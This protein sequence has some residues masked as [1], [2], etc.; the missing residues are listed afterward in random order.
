MTTRIRKMSWPAVL[1]VVMLSNTGALSMGGAG[2][3]GGGGGT[4]GGP[5]IER[6][7]E[8]AGRARVGGGRA[9]GQWFG[10]GGAHQ[11]FDGDRH[12]KRNIQRP[13]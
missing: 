9:G 7:S 3:A 10:S 13:R 8:T 1:I 6:G 5:G 11:Q 12:G 2:G 4:G